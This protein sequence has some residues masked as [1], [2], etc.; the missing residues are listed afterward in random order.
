MMSKNQINKVSIL[1]EKA[2]D[3]IFTMMQDEMGIEDG[4]L[5]SHTAGLINEKREELSEKICYGLMWQKTFNN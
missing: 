5:D 4:H 3:E 1:L 2:V